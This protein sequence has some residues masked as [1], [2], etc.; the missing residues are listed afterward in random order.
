[1][2]NQAT[3]QPTVILLVDDDDGNALV[4]EKLLSRRMR[5]SLQFRRADRL[6]AALHEASQGGIG[7]VLLDLGLPDSQGLDTLIRMRE[8]VTDVPIVVLTGLDDEEM[9]DRALQYGA[10]DYVVKGFEDGASL[11]RAIH[12]AMERGRLQRAL[13]AEHRLLLSIMENIPDQVYL[14]DTTSRFVSMNPA[15]ARFFGAPSADAMAGKTDG[16]FFSCELA[17]QFRK[18]EQ[19]LMH[20]QQDAC[21]NREAAVTGADGQTRWVLTT[22]VCVRDAAGHA[23]GVLGINRDITARKQAEEMLKEYQAHLEELVTERTA[24]LQ[25]ANERL[26][27][28]DRKR[29]QFVSNVSHELKSPLAGLQLALR[30]MQTGV[31]CPYPDRHCRSYLER[32]QQIGL[33]MQQTVEDILDMSRNDAGTLRL[34]CVRTPFSALVE[35]VVD[36]LQLQMDELSLQ[37]AVTIPD[38]PSFVECDRQRIERV[39]L[40]LLG[41]AIK[42]TSEGGEIRIALRTDD[43]TPGVL[44]LDVEDDGIGILPEHLPHIGERYFQGN[45]SPSGTGLGLSI[46]RESLELHGGTLSLT[47]PPPG[48]TKGTLVT[49][50]L[51]TVEPPE[52]VLIGAGEPCQ[53]IAAQ[54]AR[55]GYRT[56]VCRDSAEAVAAMRRAAPYAAILDFSM[57][58]LDA[59]G[60]IAQLKNDPALQSVPLMVLTEADIPETKR[61]ILAG[62]AGIPALQRPWNE[63]DLIACLERTVLGNGRGGVG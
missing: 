15:A 50:R 56:S 13:A 4:L 38:G 31:I 57:A 42:F 2:S 37:V 21:V 19:D 8:A 12:Y 47:S 34:G 25:L 3:D 7:V 27:A 45:H 28:L 9:A 40:N 52:L 22:K 62:F 36:M 63:N 10:Q 17:A 1:M 59:A 24:E 55:H 39:L 5:G 33:R 11:A 29:A 60:V 48:K 16:D 30:N 43:G 26:E 23:T 54:L 49:I 44:T 18:E 14:K 41:N 20:G 51:P 58:A 32:M 61:Q 53:T 35:R 6:S 46:S